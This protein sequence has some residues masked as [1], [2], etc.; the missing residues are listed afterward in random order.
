[1]CGGDRGSEEG[2]VNGGG[3]KTIWIDMD[4]TPHVHFFK[5][6]IEELEGRG[7]SVVLTAR[8]CFQVCDL[9]DRF[10]LPYLRI[11]RHHGKNKIAKGWG[12]LYRAIQLA[13]AIRKARP[14]L[15]ISHGSRAQV[16]LASILRIPSV[17]VIDYEFAKPFPFVHPDLLLVPEMIPDDALRGDGRR[18]GRYPGIKEDV[19]VPTFRPVP[20]ILRDL[21]IDGRDVV[22]TVRPPADEAH[23][24]NP[25][26]ME[27][28]QETM[29]WLS[30]NAG[31]RLVVLPRNEHQASLI[32]KS[33]TGM[34][35][36]GKAVIPGHVVDGLNLIWHSDLV[37]SGG[38]TMNREAAA[39]GVPVYSIFRGKIGSVDRYLADQGRLVLIESAEDLRKKIVLAHRKRPDR[40]DPGERPALKT[41]VDRMIQVMEMQ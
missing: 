8:D 23:Y 2:V 34:F 22:A 39:L 37:I 36:G 38:G 10:H 12:L 11:G 24:R 41:I 18:I 16:I 1:M 26:S 35:A 20:G 19:Y 32:R 21:G 25:K 9:A 40:P 30:G 28:F 29:D 33:W 31:V 17:M 3:E 27:L 13:P 4:N 6:V 14:G 5:P 7:Y 15:A